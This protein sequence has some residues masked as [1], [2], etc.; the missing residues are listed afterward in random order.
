MAHRVRTAQKQRE[1]EKK[2]DSEGEIRKLTK[3][4]KTLQ[5]EIA[6]LR[7]YLEKPDITAKEDDEQEPSQ[8]KAEEDNFGSC[9]QCHHN[10]H[11]VYSV[12]IG[13]SRKTWTTC[14]RCS[15]RKKVSG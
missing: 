11:S 9:E 4:N 3:E 12:M 7:R 2:Q 14:L 13:G 1:K 6:R 10:K 15:H 8:S 5:R